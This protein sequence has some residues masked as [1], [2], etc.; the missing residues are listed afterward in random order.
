M[1]TGTKEYYAEY[2]KRNKEKHNA[3]MIEYRQNNED[4]QLYQLEYHRKKYHKS[5]ENVD[6][7]ILRKQWREQ[8]AKKNKQR[9][10]FIDEYK[11]TC[12]CK[13]CGDIRPYVLDFHHLDPSTKSFDLGTATKRSIDD[14]KLE[15]QK[16]I[17]LCRNCHSEFHYLEKT[18]GTTLDIYLSQTQTND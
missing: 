10:E 4:Q 14:L 15:L 1:K 16:C 12:T 7:D 18:N 3:K 8:S 13:K 6:E 2:Y 5:K 9:R 11:S 17:T